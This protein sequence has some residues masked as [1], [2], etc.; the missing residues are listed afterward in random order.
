M[1]MYAIFFAHVFVSRHAKFISDIHEIFILGV[2]VCDGLL[3]S[4][5]AITA[6]TTTWPSTDWTCSSLSLC[7]VSVVTSLFRFDFYLFINNEHFSRQFCVL[8]SSL[9][10]SILGF[11]F[12]LN[13][14]VDRIHNCKLHFREEINMLKI[15]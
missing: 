15:K 7:A 9:L 5:T 12:C 2:S 4:L 6:T 10:V 1:R 13:E 14:T 11:A 3:S 8:F